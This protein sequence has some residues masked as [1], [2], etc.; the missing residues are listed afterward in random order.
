MLSACGNAV[1]EE[2]HVEVPAVLACE[3]G[4]S[5]YRVSGTPIQFCYDPA[6]GA[7]ASHENPGQ[8]GE[9]IFIS[10]DGAVQSPTLHYESANYLPP[11]TTVEDFCYE[12]IRATATNESLLEQIA[13]ELDV[14]TDKLSV[15]KSDAGGMRA[16]RVHAEY[17]H[18]M[19]GAIDTLTYYVPEAFPGYNVQ[20]YG[21]NE[22][23]ETVDDFVYD[24]LF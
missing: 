1:V 16:I 6:W 10:F 21:D 8:A 3:E 15:R 5:E 12:C 24:I 23:A 18:G 13:E 22:I 20:I 14:D 2:E 17:N 4:M 11:E 9:S 19:F 7:V